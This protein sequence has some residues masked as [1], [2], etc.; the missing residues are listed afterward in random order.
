[1]TETDGNPP[2]ACHLSQYV[3]TETPSNYRIAVINRDRP[4][5][6]EQLVEKLFARQPVELSDED[7]PDVDDAVVLLDEDEVVATSPLKQLNDTILLVNSDLYITGAVDIKDI[8]LPDVIAELSETTFHVRGYPESNTE[9]MPLILISRYIERLSYIHGGTHRASFQ[10]LS[11]LE[12][13]KGTRNIYNRLADEGVATHVYGVPDQL[14][15]RELGLT[16]HAGH[17]PDFESTW[18]V[19]HR[20]EDAAAALVAVEVGTNEW[21]SRWT[22]VDE[23]VADIEATVKEYL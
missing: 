5:A 4:E 19:I 15:H 14:P 12:D 18:F 6:I 20:S 8:D 16:V 22:F 1:M 9:K 10:R 23:T 7:I 3:S 17:G 13:E 2:Q 11:R 21:L